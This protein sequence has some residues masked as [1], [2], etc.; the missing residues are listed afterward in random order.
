M[1]IKA[2]SILHDVRGFVVD[3]IQTGGISNLNIP[4]TK[5]Y[6][7]GNYQSVA[8]IRDIPDLAFDIQSFDVS[9]ETEALLL[10]LDPSTVVN[11]QALDFTNSIPMDV[12]SPFKAGHGAFN[13]VKGIAIPY[14]T[15]DSVTY[16]FAVKQ[17]SQQNF[18][19]RG[20]SVYYVPGSPYQEVKS[21]VAGA[22]HTYT[23]AHTAI[24][25]VENGVDI[26]ALSVCA[27]NPSTGAFKR[28]FVTDDYTSTSSGFTTLADLDAL[29]YTQVHVTYGS[30]VVAT[31]NQTVNA[32]VGV[33]PAAVRGKDV[34]VYVSD[35][36]AT[37]TLIRWTG[38]QTFNVARTVNLAADEEL[39]NTHYVDYDY[40]TADVKGTIALRPFDAADLFTKIAQITNVPSNQVTG[41]YSSQPLEVLVKIKDPDTG[42]TLKSIEIPDARFVI[43]SVQPKANTKVDVN[44]TF[45]SDTGVM[46][47]Y[48]GDPA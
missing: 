33:K 9:T 6:E 25:Y 38:I 23:F 3:R 45:E 44:F 8:T 20:D 29:G 42:L 15:L 12:I 28:L 46:T 37:P 47:V 14:L 17:D 40:D 32:G 18:T 1:P 35:G 21:V 24:K 36:A 26:Y 11:G 7:T 34:C 4:L 13:I 5:I 31:Y 43:P 16:N 48:K 2:G 27:K 30:T 22:N 19:L 10:G 41:P 39:C